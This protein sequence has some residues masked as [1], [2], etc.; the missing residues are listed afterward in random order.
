MGCDGADSAGGVLVL[1]TAINKLSSSYGAFN[2][3]CRAEF[4][5]LEV[6]DLFRGANRGALGLCIRGVDVARFKEVI[7]NGGCESICTPMPSCDVVVTIFGVRWKGT[8][9]EKEVGVLILF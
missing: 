2:R 4:R 8:N 6:G 9:S 1:P 5:L 7:Q 3:C